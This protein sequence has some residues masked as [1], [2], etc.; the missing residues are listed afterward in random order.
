MKRKLIAVSQQ[1]VTA[2][3]KHLKQGRRS[4]LPQVG[5]LG[6]RGMVLGLETL[7]VAGNHEPGQGA[8]I[9]W[10]DSTTT[11]EGAGWWSG[12]FSVGASA[13]DEQTDFAAMQIRVQLSQLEGTLRQDPIL[14]AQGA[15]S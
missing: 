8:L 15:G 11:R 13:P 3:K 5:R 9:S 10:C 1:Y 14:R 6:H 4:S 7:D 2:S 12:T